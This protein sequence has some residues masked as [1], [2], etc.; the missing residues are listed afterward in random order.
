MPRTLPNGGGPELHLK[1][2]DAAIKQVFAPYHPGG[3]Q[4]CM[5][6]KKDEKSTIL[7]GHFDG[8]GGAPVRYCTHLPMEGVQG[9]DRSHWLTPPSEYC[10]Q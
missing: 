7:A 6:E 1:P 5:Q 4:G 3:Q 8:H 2:M 9:Y 10:G